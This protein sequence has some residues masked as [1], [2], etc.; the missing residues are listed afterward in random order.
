MDEVFSGTSPVEGEV[1]AYSIA[2]YLSKFDKSICFIAT[3]FPKLTELEKTTNGLYKNYQVKVI[4]KDDGKLIFPYKLEE[5][6]TSQNIA[7]DILQMEG[8]TPE[9]LAEA[10][11]IIANHQ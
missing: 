4:K 5:G 2:K 10:Y 9:M 1:I 3:H 7:L 6:K 11:E 8:F